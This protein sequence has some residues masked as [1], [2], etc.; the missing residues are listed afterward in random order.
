M[1]V[2]S[3]LMKIQRLLNIKAPDKEFYAAQKN[4]D[5]TRLNDVKVRRENQF[6]CKRVVDE[7]LREVNKQVQTKVS[8][9]F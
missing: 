3:T 7:E 8:L 2:L 4:E 6:K 9:T 1:I 5:L